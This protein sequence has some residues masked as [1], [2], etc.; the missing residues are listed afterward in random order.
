LVFAD[1]RYTAVGFELSWFFVQAGWHVSIYNRLGQTIGQFELAGPPGPEPSTSFFG[2]WCDQTIGRINIFDD[3][4]P[5]PD[6]IDNI[7]M[8]I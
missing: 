4:G 2:V 3:A 7:Q 8:W 6:A 1:P 5:W